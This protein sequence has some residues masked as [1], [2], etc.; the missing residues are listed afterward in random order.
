METHSKV[1][2]QGDL[3]REL[4]VKKAD[5]AEITAAVELLKKLKLDYEAETGESYNKGMEFNC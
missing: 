3:L 1:T 4:K 5:K 2:A